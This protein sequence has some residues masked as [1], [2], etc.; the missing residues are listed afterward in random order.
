MW[1]LLS[2]FYCS[3][4]QPQ[5]AGTWCRLGSQYITDWCSA[6]RSW[7]GVSN[8]HQCLYYCEFYSSYAFIYTFASHVFA[9]AGLW[10]A[11]SAV[12]Q[13]KLSHLVLTASKF[14]SAGANLA[15]QTRKLPT[16]LAAPLYSRAATLRASELM[17][18]R[19][20]SP[21]ETPCAVS[22]CQEVPVQAHFLHNMCCNTWQVLPLFLVE[23]A[24]AKG[25]PG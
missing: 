2:A 3:T 14:A 7:G 25:K 22:I 9:A 4:P 8:Q 19:S 18:S 15:S 10:P 21:A 5:V 13:K 16:P 11:V 1:W 17:W 6:G 20:R 12:R 23:F 24:S